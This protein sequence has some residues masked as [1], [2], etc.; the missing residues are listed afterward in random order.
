MKFKSW[1]LIPIGILLQLLPFVGAM[2]SSSPTRW[3][4][5]FVAII[6]FTL[7]ILCGISLI[8]M[9]L[10]IFQKTR[11]IGAII[12]IIAGIDIIA[13]MPFAFIIVIF[14]VIAGILALWKN[15]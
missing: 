3:G 11:K 1:Y 14:L 6:G 2:S 4:G 7:L 8:P 9:F 12:S 5:F 13:T 10:L 15:M